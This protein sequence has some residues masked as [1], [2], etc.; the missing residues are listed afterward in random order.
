MKL[1]EWIASMK[2]GHKK[3]TDSCIV[4]DHED[5]D[6]SHFY[7]KRHTSQN[8]EWVPESIKLLYEEFDGMDLFSSTF[9]ICSLKEPIVIGGVTI[10]T[11]IS[12]LE[13]RMSNIKFPEPALPF[14]K[15]TGNW[16]YAASLNSNWIYSF[17]IEYGSI[18]K[19]RSFYEIIDNW[20]TATED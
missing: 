18:D 2:T 1:D 16:I 10:I 5:G 19:H 9:K 6:T 3:Q 8:L 14:M 4:I 12:E 11:S 20:L 17:D 7:I 15:E 13:E